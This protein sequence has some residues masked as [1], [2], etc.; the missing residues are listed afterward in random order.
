MSISLKT[1]ALLTPIFTT[2]FWA[3]V[4][5]FRNHSRRNPGFYIAL[6]MA[7]FSMLF[8][9]IFPFYTRN[10]DLYMAMEPLFFFSLNMV[11]PMVFFYI[12]AVTLRQKLMVSDLP[13]ILPALLLTVTSLVL[14]TIVPAN[15]L[16]GYARGSVSFLDASYPQSLFFLT[17]YLS[18]LVVVIQIVLYCFLCMKLIARHKI[19][20]NNY[21]SGLNRS[22]F[23][24]IPFFYMTY[25][26]ASLLGLYLILKGN[27]YI[28]GAR[29]IEIIV[30]FFGLSIIFFTI[31]LV[32]NHQRYIEN[33]EFYLIPDSSAQETVESSP[34]RLGKLRVQVERYFIEEQ[35]WLNA[36]LKITDVAAHL[37]TNRTY[38][39][40]LIKK[41]FNKNFKTYVNS[42]RVAEAVRLFSQKKYHN[43]STKS[44]SELSGFN[45]YNS[46]VHAFRL[47][48][49][50]TPGAFR[51]KNAEDLR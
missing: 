40:E 1:I 45:S 10:M 27:S 33:K 35:P 22:L 2:F 42:F 21:F 30:S 28:D 23:N 34:G 14:H 26:A 19:Q 18:K 47:E 17:N 12:R 15:R 25:P 3:L 48:T 44:I 36:D 49:G 4:I 5:F 39:S 20:V 43:F 46:F 50:M 24:W 13:H 38:I 31:A 41:H 29:D 51:E 8:S 7:F 16:T 9:S 6:L 32:T 11:F 37:D